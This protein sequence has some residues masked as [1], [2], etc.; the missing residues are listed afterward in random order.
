MTYQEYFRQ[1][2]FAEVW[3]IICEIYRESEETRPLYQ[4][5][6]QSVCEMVVDK[7]HSLPTIEVEICSNGEIYVMG[8]PDPQE[9]LVGREVKI[10]WQ[11]ST[12]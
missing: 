8:A 10:D 4:A 3:K 12:D 2:N 9:W 11:S 7:F 1:A 6:H 5:V